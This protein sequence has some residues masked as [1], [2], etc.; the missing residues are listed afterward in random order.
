MAE[1]ERKPAESPEEFL[2][3]WSRR[4]RDAREEALKPPA[5]V[6]P[7]TAEEPPPLPPVEEMGIDS[8]YRGF[9]HPKVDE[10]LRRAA[11]K[12]MFSDPHFNVMDGL[13]VYIDDYSISDPLPASMLA[14]L[15]QAQKIFG[16]AKETDEQAQQRRAMTPQQKVEAEAAAEAASLAAQEKEAVPPPSIEGA[17]EPAPVAQKPD[18]DPG[19]PPQTA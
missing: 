11:L 17:T 13:D 4:K 8:D 19:A 5:P 18:D 6:T 3:R 16:W 12:K 9:L 10:T 2:S 14:E 15:K 1:S 7:A